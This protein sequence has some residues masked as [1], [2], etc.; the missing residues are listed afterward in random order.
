MGSGFTF[1]AINKLKQNRLLIK[2][3]NSYFNLKKHYTKVCQKENI[4]FQ[5]L[6][7]TQLKFIRRKVLAEKSISLKKNLIKV[8][9]SIFLTIILLYVLVK[10]FMWLALG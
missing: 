4:D 3:R 8:F 2:N 6:D 10:L 1:D 5:T 7:E 9:L